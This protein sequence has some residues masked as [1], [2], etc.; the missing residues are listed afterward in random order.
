VFSGRNDS[1]GEV[2]AKMAEIRNC[3][4]YGNGAQFHLFVFGEETAQPAV[5]PAPIVA[6]GHGFQ[7][8][9]IA[10]I[11]GKTSWT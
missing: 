3:G 11:F 9:S 8:D 5:L 7:A 6:G 2:E 4:E 1:Q 10:M